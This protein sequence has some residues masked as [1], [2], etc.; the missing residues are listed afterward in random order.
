MSIACAFLVVSPDLSSGYHIGLRFD[1]S[2]S[3][4]YFPVS[5]SC[6]NSE[7][8]RVGENLSQLAMQAQGWFGEAQL[9][10]LVKQEDK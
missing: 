9:E 3:E 4:E 10:R 8:R 6:R 5:N 7:C 1:G 2:R